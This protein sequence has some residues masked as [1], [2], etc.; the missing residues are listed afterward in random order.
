[1]MKIAIDIRNIGKGR[2]GDE[3]VF[4]EL[5]K[6]L[7]QIDDGQDEYMLL[8]DQRSENE[9]SKVAKRL[10]IHDKDNFTIVELGIANKFMWNIWNVPKYCRKAK[11]DIYHTQYI[12][13]FFMPKR[14]KIV[15]HIHD[16]SFRAHPELISKVDSFFLN[17]LIP[18]AVRKSHKVIAVSQ[19][20]KDEIVKYYKVKPEKI[21]VIY[22]AVSEEYKDAEVSN[23]VRKKYNLPKK[24]ILSLGTMQPRKNIPFLIA[25]FAQV[26]KRIDDV[27]LVLVGKQAHNFD[28]SITKVINQ[29]PQ[30]KDKVLFTGYVDEKDKLAIFERAKVFVFPSLYEGFGVPILEAFEAGVPV[31]ASDIVPHREI[32][33]AGALYCDL[34]NIDQCKK[35][36]YDVLINDKIREY[37]LIE[38][39]KQKTIFSWT[40]SARR[41]QNLYREEML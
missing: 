39:K 15:T 14:T 7:A 11:I 4:F 19:F 27:Y 31:V 18:R 13:P 25:M 1:M 36:L 17:A 3:V 34:K 30:I 8:I 40:E 37:A 5:V 10:G 38:S 41:L 33:G 23:D 6:N 26:A 22:N 24:Y 20:T 32:G 9:I 35:M 21:V 2:T 12:I 16:V 28:S 29:Y